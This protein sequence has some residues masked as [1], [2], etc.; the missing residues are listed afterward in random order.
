MVTNFLVEARVEND[1]TTD[2]EM[3]PT[4]QKMHLIVGKCMWMVP[5]EMKMTKL[6]M[7]LN[8]NKG[9]LHGVKT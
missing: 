8:K 3:L 9:E 4:N 5:W 6:Q 2:K 7:T 1:F